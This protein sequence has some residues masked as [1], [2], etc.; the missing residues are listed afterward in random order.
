[1]A[2]QATARCS[3]A[4][5]RAQEGRGR[6]LARLPDRQAIACRDRSAYAR[7]SWGGWQAYT[8]RRTV[9]PTRRRNL[10]A[11][12]S[13]RADRVWTRAGARTAF[14]PRAPP[15]HLRAYLIS[16]PQRPRRPFGIRCPQAD[17]RRARPRESGVAI[18][19]AVTKAAC[20]RRSAM[21]AIGHPVEPHHRSHYATQIHPP[22]SCPHLGSSS[23]MTTARDR[24]K[25]LSWSRSIAA[26]HLKRV[27]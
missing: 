10:F 1:M 26:P 15:R 14:A 2:T 27:R 6:L 5:S 7:W 21:P 9:A 25:R 20:R 17:R 16:S 3:T 13:R 23:D 8:S 19:V 4:S 11:R 12:V 24:G 22:R 18:F